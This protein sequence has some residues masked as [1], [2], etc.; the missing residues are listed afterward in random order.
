MPYRNLLYV[1]LVAFINHEHCNN[2][3]IETFLYAVCMYLID[4]HYILLI[5][6]SVAKNK[7][8]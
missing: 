7:A 4:A 6:T 5:F 3:S 8:N 1:T 2:F